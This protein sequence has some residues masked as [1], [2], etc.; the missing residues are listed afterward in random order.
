MELLYDPE[1]SFG[2]GT[3]TALARNQI[4]LRRGWVMFGDLDRIPL[5]G[6]IGK[7]DIPF[8]LNDTVNPFTNSTNWHAFSG[9]AYGVQVGLFTDGLHLRGM[10]VQGGSQF[11]GANNPVQGSSTPSRVNNFAFDANY[12]LDFAN[13]AGGITAG[14]SYLHGT[15]YCQ[16]YPVVHFNPCEDNNP[17]IAT[18]GRLTYDGLTLLGEYAQTTR[19]WPGTA[20]PD[21]NNPLSDFAAVRASSLTVGG[22]YGFGHADPDSLEEEFALSLEYSRF[23]SGDDGS[24]WKRQNQVVLGGSWYVVPSANLFAEFVHIDG[25]VPLNFLSGGNL[26]DGSTHSVNEANTN[27]IIIGGQFAF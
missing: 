27:A 15:A 1:Q 10:A 25:Y 14:F 16:G 6:L 2:Q 3:I 12:T 19:I 22:R 23:V 21:L 11:R 24:P 13:D 5:Y 7:M 8:G 9:L 26:P 18:Y 4:Q 20:V 17:G